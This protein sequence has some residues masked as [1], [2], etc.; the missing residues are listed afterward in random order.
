MTTQTSVQWLYL[1]PNGNSFYRQ[2]FVKGTR[3]RARV[4]YGLHA[5]V[6]EPMTAAK[7]AAD[8]G[9]PLEAVQEAISY[10]QT[11]PPEIE[12]DLQREDLLVKATG[13]HDPARKAQ[14]EPKPLPAQEMARI[15]ES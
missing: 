14:G 7:I 1:A 9:L 11:N 6:E 4:L 5:S 3:I 10:C 13:M 2:L 12:A 15:R 8:Y